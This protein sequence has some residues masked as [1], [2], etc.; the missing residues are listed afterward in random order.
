MGQQSIFW[1]SR[2]LAWLI[3]FFGFKQQMQYEPEYHASMV[4]GDDI[5]TRKCEMKSTTLSATSPTR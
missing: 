1:R 2:I 4:S 5:P 3:I